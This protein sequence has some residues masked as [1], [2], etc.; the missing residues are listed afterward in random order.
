[1]NVRS[2][3]DQ[4]GKYLGIRA[5]I[6]DISKLKQAF[7]KIH[8]LETDKHFTDLTK[9][10]MQNEMHQKDRELVSFLLQLS[11][12]NELLA[13]IKKQ[14]LKIDQQGTAEQKNDL[15]SL[16]TVL[17]TK[18]NQLIEWG[19]VENQVEKIYPGFLHNLQQKHPRISSNDKKICAYL[20]L[21]LSNKEISGLLNITPKSVEVARTR[22]RKKLR[23]SSKTRLVTYLANL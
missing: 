16:L 6:H 1:M 20:K 12:Q 15:K 14:F 19:I 18:Q 11:Q 2:V 7:N 8:N 9:S 13:A 17:E 22:L 3:Y 10:R 21:G 4:Q 23:V 5:S